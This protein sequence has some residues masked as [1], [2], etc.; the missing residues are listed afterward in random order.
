MSTAF[1]SPLQS[2]MAT[3]GSPQITP[4]KHDTIDR[5]AVPLS[6]FTRQRRNAV[7]QANDSLSSNGFSDVL[8]ASQAFR[9]A[10]WSSETPSTSLLSSPAAW[11]ADTIYD[12]AALHS[13]PFPAQSSSEA[14]VNSIGFSKESSASA[15]TSVAPTLQ[16]SLSQAANIGGDTQDGYF[17]ALLMNSHKLS[18]GQHPG[19]PLQPLE[20]STQESFGLSPGF[21]ILSPGEGHGPMT[22]LPSTSFPSLT[23]DTTPKATKERRPIHSRTRSEPEMVLKTAP[24]I[25]AYQVRV[26]E[27]RVALHEL[28][29]SLAVTFG[30]LQLGQRYLTEAALE[31]HEAGSLSGAIRAAIAAEFPEGGQSLFASPTTL[32]SGARLGCK[33]RARDA[34]IRSML[35]LNRV[36]TVAIRYAQ[37]QHRNQGGRSSFTEAR[38]ADCTAWHALREVFQSQRDSWDLLLACEK[39]IDLH[40]CLNGSRPN[41]RP[42]SGQGSPPS[43]LSSNATLAEYLRLATIWEPSIST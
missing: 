8:N 18:S 4:D 32:K 10:I 26:R 17:A 29:S 11:T 31:V 40:R 19:M 25:L 39:R 33:Q 15:T 16:P 37:Q 6:A 42:S 35:R 34:E 1:D 14:D 43:S 24:R 22:M 23:S 5:C 3:F 38:Q 12:S 21:P 13:Y 30:S 20:S 7:S 27:Q 36:C 2:R 28:L 9:S 41:S